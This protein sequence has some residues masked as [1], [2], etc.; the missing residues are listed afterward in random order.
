MLLSTGTRNSNSPLE[1]ASTT[2]D[3]RHQLK[4]HTGS[5]SLNHF[6]LP[7]GSL[8]LNMSGSASIKGERPP[9]PLPQAILYPGGEKTPLGGGD[10]T[11]VP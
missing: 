11:R 10:H 3:C 8:A 5:G 9:T 6:L 7:P 4:R 1:T 2:S